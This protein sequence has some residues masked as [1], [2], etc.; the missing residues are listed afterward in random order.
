MIIKQGKRIGNSY[1]LRFLKEVARIDRLSII[2][3]IAYAFVVSIAD[4]ITTYLPKVFVDGILD[5]NVV[6]ARRA[7][8]AFL[9]V[10]VFYNIVAVICAVILSDRKE[11]RQMFFV[12]RLFS[13]TFCVKQEYVEGTQ[14]Y[15]EYSMREAN[16]EK[17]VD[18]VMG[19][20]STLVQ[21]AATVLFIISAVSRINLFI[22]LIMVVPI[23]INLMIS[24]YVN[25]L[26][27]EEQKEKQRY[28]KKLKVLSRIF[29]LSNSIRDIKMLGMVRPVMGQLDDTFEQ[30]LKIHNRYMRKSSRLLCISSVITEALPLVSMVVFG[31]YVFTG[32]ISISAYYVYIAFYAKLKLSIEGLLALFP[33]INN[34]SLWMKDYYDYIDNQDIVE[35]NPEPG[36]GIGT[37]DTIEFRHVS[38]QYENSGQYALKDISFRLEK[39]SKNVII[40]LNGAGKSTLLKLL[41][42]VYEPSSGEVLLNGRDMRELPREDVRRLMSVL[43]QDYYIFPFTIREN[44]TAFEE[45]M[46]M[47]RRME[48]LAERFGILEKIRKL[49]KGFDTGIKAEYHDDYTDMSGGEFQKLAIM[50]AFCR[51]DVDAVLLDEP[52]NNIDIATE[53]V[54]YEFLAQTNDKTIILISHSLKYVPRADKIIYVE[55]GSIV[56]EGRHDELLKGSEKYRNLYQKYAEKYMGEEGTNA[57]I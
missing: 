41:C 1:F 32:R 40:G 52:L 29:Y 39:N 17:A 48:Q 45:G 6:L 36:A 21:Q 22:G 46:E 31:Y 55:A 30:R 43:F 47:E 2:I 14:F 28:D 49:N 50:R 37:I 5:K 38:F 33:E 11:K 24:L 56:A 42:G 8:A 34:I 15:N 54:F 10:I 4:I 23:L 53:D 27:I 26:N 44:V 20:F 57:S 7:V 35:K 13:H 12:E 16:L 25:G 19:S 3:T 18:H 51:P 9:S